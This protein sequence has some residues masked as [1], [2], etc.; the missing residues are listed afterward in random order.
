MRKAKDSGSG[1]AM[2]SPRRERGMEYKTKIR[3]NERQYLAEVGDHL[4][5]VTEDENG[6]PIRWAIFGGNK[7]EEK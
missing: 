4:V 1:E 2:T 6:K 3:L 5:I 7:E